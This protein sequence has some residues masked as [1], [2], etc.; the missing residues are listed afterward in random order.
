MITLIEKH[1]LS[2]L[3]MSTCEPLQKRLRL[4]FVQPEPHI[5][6]IARSI[7]L[8]HSSHSTLSLPT[9]RSNPD[10]SPVPYPTVHSFFTT[11]RHFG[12]V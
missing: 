8:V 7:R 11:V 1:L 2:L 10:C 3:P 4:P 6:C 12:H 9:P 5:I